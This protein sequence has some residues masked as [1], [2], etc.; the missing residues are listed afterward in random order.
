MKRAMQSV[1][2]ATAQQTWDA[3]A[4]SFDTTRNRPW[5][6]CLQFIGSL[7]KTDIV[8][9]LGCGNGRHLFPCAEHCSFVYGIDISSK[10]LRI[11]EKKIQT[12]SLHNVSL[13]HADLVSLPFTDK[14]LSVVLCIASL[15]NI[16]GKINRRAALTEIAR[17]LKP[18]GTALI[19][20]WSRWQDKF[21]KQFLSQSILH[22]LTVGDIDI[23][24][25]QHNLSVPRFYHLYSRGEFYRDL[26]GANL[27][28]EHIKSLRIHSKRFPDNYFAVVQKR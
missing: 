23:Y 28:I 13:I 22:P 3:I 7:K 8:A 25:K 27:H 26:E 11:V 15:H 1:Y 2:R 5:E 20:V 17:V 19:S 4:E 21:Y 10:L 9:D 16:Q 12:K 18:Q 24:W 14:S 6:Y